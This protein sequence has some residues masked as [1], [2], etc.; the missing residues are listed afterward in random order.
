MTSL[1]ARIRVSMKNRPHESIVGRFFYLA[2][3]L[4]YSRMPRV[5]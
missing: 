5:Q 3:A 2:G 1:I 4:R